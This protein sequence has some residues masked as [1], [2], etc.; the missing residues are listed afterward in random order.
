MLVTL[1]PTFENGA[2]PGMTG[3]LYAL[4]NYLRGTIAGFVKNPNGGVQWPAFGSTFS[5]SDVA[6]LGNGSTVASAG[7]AIRDHAEVYKACH[8]YKSIYDA[9]EAVTL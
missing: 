7:I 2:V 3:E 5:P 4:A 9:I 1:S 6:V 8:L